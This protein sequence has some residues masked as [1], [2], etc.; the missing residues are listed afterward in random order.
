MISVARVLY[1]IDLKLNK[2]ATG[3]HQ[4]IPLEDKIIALN[5]AQIALVKTKLH[6]GGPELSGLDAF[7][8]RYDDL[9]NLI[10]PHMRLPVA[11]D[12]I[13]GLHK[14]SVRMDNL[15]PACMF[16]V[17]SYFLCNKGACSGQPVVTRR[18]KHADLQAVLANA[19]TG[20]SFEYREAPVTVSDQLLEFY[21]D[22]TFTPSEAYL[23]YLHYPQKIDMEG[24]LDFDGSPSVTRDSELK[25][26]LAD[27]L[28]DLAVAAL[29]SSTENQAAAAYAGMRIQNNP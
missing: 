16:Y 21:T 28:V 10:Q 18:V 2:V 5:Q 22:G 1:D 6:A 4:S 7:K 29:A 3:W 11:A 14:Y 9:E 8:R 13:S 17:D 27:E 25:A 20:P 26:Y 15:A 12:T 23:S 19:N 24:Y